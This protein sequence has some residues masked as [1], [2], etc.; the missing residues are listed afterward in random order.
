MPEAFFDCDREL[1]GPI[2]GPG[3]QNIHRY[4]TSQL[5]EF[6]RITG[7]YEEGRFHILCQTTH[8]IEKAKMLLQESM[9]FFE[10]QRANRSQRASPPPQ[11]APVLPPIPNTAVVAA[12]P[13]WFDSQRGGVLQVAAPQG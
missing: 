3:G 7:I 4:V 1:I 5:Q 10:R 6:S 8:G 11:N 13:S 12:T 9:D 2:I